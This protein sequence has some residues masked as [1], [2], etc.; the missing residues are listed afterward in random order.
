MLHVCLQPNYILANLA[1]TIKSVTRITDR[2][3][4]DLYNQQRH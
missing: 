1:V 2:P 3:P 4:E